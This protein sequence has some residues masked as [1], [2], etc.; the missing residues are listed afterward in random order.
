MN[1]INVGK[2]SERGSSIRE[3]KGEGQ[4]HGTQKES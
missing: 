2:S 3:L 1:G 4:G